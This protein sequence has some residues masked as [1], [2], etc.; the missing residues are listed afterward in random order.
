MYSYV[1]GNPV[2]FN[3]PTGHWYRLA[4]SRRR[5]SP[6]VNQFGSWI[7]LPSSF[8]GVAQKPA[9]PTKP[10]K[11][12]AK[13]VTTNDP[14][15]MKLKQAGTTFITANEVKKNKDPAKVYKDTANARNPTAGVGHSLTTPNKRKNTFVTTITQSVLNARSQNRRAGAA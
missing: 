12:V 9:P 14:S 7:F 4:G 13:Q 5:G 11:A 8:N 2:N 6:F 1:H 10:L 15:K 3:D